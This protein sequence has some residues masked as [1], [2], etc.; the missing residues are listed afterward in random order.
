MTVDLLAIAAH[1]D[2]VELTCGGT[3]IRAVDQGYSTG[4]LDLTQ[5][6]TGTRGSAELRAA[7]AAK[8]AAVMGVA[9]RR[10][11]ELP[12]AH[13]ANTDAMRRVVV[14][15][16]RSFAPRV[17][18]LPYAVGRHPDHRIASE[19]GRDACFLAGLAR[20]DAAGEPHRPHKILYALAY[21]EDPV[22][23]TFVV[24]ISEQFERK[25]Q[26]IR[27][28][29]SQF[30]GAKAA[31]EIFPTGQDLYSLVEAQGRRYGSLIRRAF[32]EPYFTPE[33]MLVDDVVGLQVQS[34]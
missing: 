11:A 17:V 6:E 5:G 9:E 4:I 30:D 24:E 23:P 25:M 28:Y 16:I 34:M 20:Y 3:L 15:H 10:N 7:E 26:A 33:T 18:I 13:L 27:C 2:D 12:D 19:L 14:E 8:A 21:R 31:G 29:A 22:A 1:R 32:G